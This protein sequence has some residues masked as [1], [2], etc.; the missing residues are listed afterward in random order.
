MLLMD[1][2]ILVLLNLIQK[3]NFLKEYTMPQGE[4]QLVMPYSIILIETF[5]LVCAVD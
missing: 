3:G 4:Q 5:D 1:I 2:F